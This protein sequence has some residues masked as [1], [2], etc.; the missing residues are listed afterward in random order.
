MSKKCINAAGA[1]PAI[2]P[3]SHAT[4]AGDFVYLSGQIALKPDG[5]GLLKGTIEEET[6]QVFAN[7]QAVLKATGATLSDVV[8][9]CVFLADLENFAAFNKVYQGYF[10]K[11]PP[12]RTTFQPGRLPA[13]AQVEIEV[14]AWLGGR[15]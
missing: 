5:S 7:I 9:V 2:G 13:N 8:K 6:H 14:T 15:K 3:Y 11:D 12:V 1:P 4:V 10:P